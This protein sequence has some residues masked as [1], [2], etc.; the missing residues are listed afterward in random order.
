MAIY[1][2][3]QA[4]ECPFITYE[5]PFKAYE[6]PFIGY[7]RRLRTAEETFCTGRIEIFIGDM[8]KKEPGGT[9]LV[10]WFCPVEIRM[11]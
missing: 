9:I 3:F 5:C 2:S 1:F 4:F 8:L 7:E 10:G 11:K 6:R